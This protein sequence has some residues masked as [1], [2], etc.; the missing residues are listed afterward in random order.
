MTD[1]SVLQNIFH[2]VVEVPRWTN[3]K[4]EV[5]SLNDYPVPCTCGSDLMLL[6]VIYWIKIFFSQSIKLEASH[7]VIKPHFCVLLVV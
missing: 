5:G 7:L 4:M 3:A 2:M 6:V 1:S